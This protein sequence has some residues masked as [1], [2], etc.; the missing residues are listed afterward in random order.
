MIFLVTKGTSINLQF[1]KA[2]VYQSC[3]D[4]PRSKIVQIFA[5][6]KFLQKKYLTFITLSVGNCRLKRCDKVCAKFCHF[7]EIFKVLPK[8]K[9]T[10]NFFTSHWANFH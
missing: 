5:S 7:G 2:F 6:T 1:S 10:S 3:A 9:F 4:L 8:P